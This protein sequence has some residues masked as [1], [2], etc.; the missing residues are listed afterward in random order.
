MEEVETYSIGMEVL[1]KYVD[2]PSGTPVFFLEGSGDSVRLQVHREDYD[3]FNTGD[4][5]EVKVIKL[6]S[7][8]FKVKA[9]MHTVLGAVIED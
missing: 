2:R 1:E 9:T 3:R 8:I 4:I 5:V 6:E 7:N